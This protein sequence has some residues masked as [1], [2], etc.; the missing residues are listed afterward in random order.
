MYVSYKYM[1]ILNEK[2]FN[3]SLTILDHIISIAEYVLY[4]MPSETCWGLLCCLTLNMDEITWITIFWALIM[5][6]GFSAFSVS[7]TFY[8]IA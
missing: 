8:L 1:Y 7:I 4:K 2:Y 3:F 6:H 5:F